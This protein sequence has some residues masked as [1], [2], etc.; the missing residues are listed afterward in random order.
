MRRCERSRLCRLERGFPDIGEYT[1]IVRDYLPSGE[2]AAYVTPK[3]CATI[4]RNSLQ[5]RTGN[6]AAGSG[7]A[8]EYGPRGSSSAVWRN[9]G[10]I[11]A[12]ATIR[13]VDWRGPSAVGWPSWAGRRA[14]EMFACES[15]SRRHSS[16]ASTKAQQV[17]THRRAAQAG[18]HSTQR[19]VSRCATKRDKPAA[20]DRNPPLPA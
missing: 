2:A 1:G 19:Y 3:S 7:N 6:S 18:G 17:A 10:A 15:G 9:L 12:A 5:Q 11:R 20:A 14:G 16:A 8:R 13:P 4:R